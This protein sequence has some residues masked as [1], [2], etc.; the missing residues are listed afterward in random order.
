VPSAPTH[1]WIFAGS[2]TPSC[3]IVTSEGPTASAS[4]MLATIVIPID[5]LSI[6]F[7]SRPGDVVREAAR[8]AG[9]RARHDSGEGT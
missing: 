8:S 1:A 3:A 5:F 4:A 6:R 7:P 9:G 2:P